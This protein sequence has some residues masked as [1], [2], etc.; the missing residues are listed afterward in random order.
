MPSPGSDF[1][2]S[3]SHLFS[4]AGSG[5]RDGKIE[6]AH[7]RATLIKF[8]SACSRMTAAKARA[9]H[10]LKFIDG[11]EPQT[12]LALP[13][14]KLRIDEKMRAELE[15]TTTGD[16]FIEILRDLITKQVSPRRS[17]RSRKNTSPVQTPPGSPKSKAQQRAEAAQKN[18]KKTVRIKLRRSGERLGTDEKEQKTQTQTQTKQ[19][20]TAI[21]SRPAISQEALARL[22]PKLAQLSPKPAEL[23]P[24]PAELVPKSVQSVLKKAQPAPKSAPKSAPK[25]A[26]KPAP[27]QNLPGPMDLDANDDDDS[28]EGFASSESSDSS[29]S[30]DQSITYSDNGDTRMGDAVI[31]KV[32]EAAGAWP[33]QR[34][35]HISEVT[36]AAAKCNTG[37]EWESF[38]P[39]LLD[40]LARIEAD[41][42]EEEIEAALQ[43]LEQAVIKTKSERQFIPDKTWQKYH[44]KL[45]KDAKKGWF[46]K[47][48]DDRIWRIGKICYLK[49][50]EAVMVDRNWDRLRSAAKMCAI[51][52]EMTAPPQEP[53]KSASIDKWLAEKLNNVTF[54]KK[55]VECREHYTAVCGF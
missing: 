33:A 50:E 28:S 19:T 45:V 34:R 2:D 42:T 9:S 53:N 54:A 47:N 49:E 7:L 24:K 46:E 43:R 35:P 5:G 40:M 21:E 55:A 1:L 31:P 6:F 36:A 18:K 10:N 23:V 8:V 14:G 52:T 27:A 22:V 3:L 16:E 29:S 30:E 13:P 12:L 11:S 48:W 44:A 20:E 15:A 38:K 51:I 17:P 26:P 32:E 4:E 37:G 25:P 39:K 41:A